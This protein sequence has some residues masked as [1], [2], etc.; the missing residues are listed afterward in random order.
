[1]AARYGDSRQ[2]D[3]QDV[4]RDT[5]WTRYTITFTG[6]H[7]IHT[8]A[9]VSELVETCSWSCRTLCWYRVGAVGVF[10]VERDYTFGSNKTRDYTLPLH[11]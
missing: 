1:M 8:S 9:E 6:L 5:Q 11:P 10:D 7:I 4:L 2:Q 3:E